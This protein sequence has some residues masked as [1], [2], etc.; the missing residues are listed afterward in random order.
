MFKWL[1]TFVTNDI[2]EGL[3]LEL[4]TLKKDYKEK[5][6]DADNKLEMALMM[7]RMRDAD[8]LRMNELNA[9]VFRLE[10]EVDKM[11][12]EKQVLLHVLEKRDQNI[13]I[14]ELLK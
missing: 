11:R 7:D 3:E 13:D 8:Q 2:I 14:T 9:V 12:T 10:S 6:E 1:N 4:S 5:I